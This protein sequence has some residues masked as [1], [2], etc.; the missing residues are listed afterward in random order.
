M[1]LK[2]EN[3]T[4][5]TVVYYC[6]AGYTKHGT[7]VIILKAEY[8]KHCKAVNILGAEYTTYQSSQYP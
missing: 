3:Y 5:Y 7:S 2:Q 4:S 1:Y 6:E 8:T